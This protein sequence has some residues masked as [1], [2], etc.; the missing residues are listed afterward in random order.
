M[1]DRESLAELEPEPEP[2][3]EPDDELLM[4]LPV[5]WLMLSGLLI[6]CGLVP[7]G[8]RGGC[9]GLKNCNG[10]GRHGEGTGAPAGCG[11]GGSDS[12][13]DDEASPPLPADETGAAD[14]E[15]VAA[16]CCCS[17]TSADSDEGGSGGGG[18][19]LPVGESYSC[20]CGV[21]GLCRL[22]HGLARLTAGLARLALGLCS[23]PS[24]GGLVR[25][26]R[27]LA[28]KPPGLLAEWRY[29]SPSSS[30]SSAL[31]A[32]PGLPLLPRLSS[33]WLPESPLS[34]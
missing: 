30:P 17:E 9:T 25:L 7:T 26:E 31:R 24:D 6:S 23:R 2:M 15:V 3:L 21:S 34:T 27:P 32:S 28:L 16:R 11:G 5:S 19:G 20:G 1:A 10:N 12:G 13:P 33:D 29:D 8:W 18:G 14:E 22:M 4:H